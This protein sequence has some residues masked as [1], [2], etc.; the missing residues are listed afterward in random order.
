MDPWNGPSISVHNI[1][2]ALYYS[3]VTTWLEYCVRCLLLDDLDSLSPCFYSAF[4]EADLYGFPCSWLVLIEVTNRQP[5]QEMKEKR[6]RA[7][8]LFLDPSIQ[9]CL[10]LAVSLS[11]RP[12]LPR[13]RTSPLLHFPSVL[14]SQIPH[15]EPRKVID[16]LLLLLLLSCF[17]R[18]WLCATP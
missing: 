4:W 11:W 3:T 8:Y 5:W 10:C 12:L 15:F 16:L 14:W 18:V 17:S 6:L 13:R 9:V 1:S 7:G 2:I